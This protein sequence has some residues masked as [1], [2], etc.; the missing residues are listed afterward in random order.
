M[1]SDVAA[2]RA[3]I[4]R[5]YARPKNRPVNLTA[6]RINELHRLRHA[7]YPNGITDDPKG[8]VL[9]RVLIHHLAALPGDPRKRL[10]RWIEDLAPW[11]PVGDARGLINEALT[12]PRTWR[13]DRLAWRLGLNSAD[14]AALK[15]TTIGAIDANKGQRQAQRREAARAL[16][17]AKRRA[18]GAKPRADYLAAVAAPKPWISLGISRATWFRRGK[19]S[20]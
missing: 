18:Q 20:A 6:V 14:R 13:A 17:E 5:R 16:R 19:P 11:M 8:R 1:S 4:A 15:I 12:K 7:R 2:K 9:V 3:E 10:A